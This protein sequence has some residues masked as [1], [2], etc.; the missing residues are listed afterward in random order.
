MI[1][2]Y[3]GK[4]HNAFPAELSFISHSRAMKYTVGCFKGGNCSVN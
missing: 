2:Q 1:N 3:E 4:P